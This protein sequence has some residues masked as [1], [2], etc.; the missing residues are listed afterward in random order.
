[1]CDSGKIPIPNIQIPN[2]SQ[3]TN[4]K[5]ERRLEFGFWKLELVWDLEIGIWNLISVPI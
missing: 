5:I 1:M 2:K 4:F 3:T